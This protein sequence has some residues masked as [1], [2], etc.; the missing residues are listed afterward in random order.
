MW[1]MRRCTN[2]RCLLPS[3]PP[4]Y[5]LLQDLS[6]FRYFLS[7]MTW[8][9]LNSA[10]AEKGRKA[11]QCFWEKLLPKLWLL[12]PTTRIC[13]WSQAASDHRLEVKINF[14]ESS[15]PLTFIISERRLSYPH[16]AFITLYKC[17]LMM[18]CYLQDSPTH[19]NQQ[20]YSRA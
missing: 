12:S 17:C 8:K 20:A 3:A 13:W 14:L 10:F 2:P 5:G 18:Y 11:E 7:S 6:A 16:L 4:L 1:P 19:W 15:I 9:T